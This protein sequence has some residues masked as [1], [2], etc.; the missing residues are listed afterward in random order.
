[1]NESDI[2]KEKAAGAL[3]NL[4]QHKKLKEEIIK[5]GKSFLAIVSKVETSRMRYLKKLIED[6]TTTNV[7][8]TY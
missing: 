1:M 8:C 2:I 4:A 5:Q 3:W 6:D 7:G